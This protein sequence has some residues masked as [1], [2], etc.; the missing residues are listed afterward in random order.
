MKCPRIRAEPA[1]RF[2]QT[3]LYVRNICLATSFSPQDYIPLC[4]QPLHT[5]SSYESEQEEI[6]PGDIVAVRHGQKG[7]Q[8][9]LVIGS[10]IDYH[11]RQIIEVQLE[12]EVYKAWYPTVTR[13]K[14]TLYTRP[15][16]VVKPRTI[17]RRIYW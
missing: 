9:G 15:H 14:R 12:N 10:H 4:Y 17:E 3:E 7:R 5:M 11:G 1:P 6:A 8:E 13:V 16:T 2:Q